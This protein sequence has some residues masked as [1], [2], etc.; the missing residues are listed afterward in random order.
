MKITEYINPLTWQPPQLSCDNPIS[1]Q[2]KEPL[3]NTAHFMAFIGAAGSGKTSAAISWLTNKDMYHKVFNN[4]FVVMPPNSRASLAGNIFKNH[5]PEKLFDDLTF[6]VLDFVK[7]YCETESPLDH[8]S[9]LFIDDCAAAL[10]DANIQKILKS[11]IFNRRH[12][13][14]SI[15]IMTQSYN[16]MNLSIRKNLSHAVIFKPRNRKEL[17]IIFSELMFLSKDEQLKLANHVWKEPHSFLYMNTGS[18]KLYKN[19]NLL[20]FDEDN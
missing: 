15:Q 20:Q 13:K 16:Q 6:S 1:K 19:F 14:L 7:S 11:L 3:P 5:P 10:K 18:N 8:H 9:L 17:E 4:I 12:L 2:I